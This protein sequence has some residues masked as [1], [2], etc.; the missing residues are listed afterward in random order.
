MLGKHRTGRAHSP[1]D[2]GDQPDT[3]RRQ[4]LRRAGL[5]GA[6]AAALAGTADLAGMSSALAAAGQQNHQHGTNRRN[7]CLSCVY[8]PGHCNGGRPCPSGQCC[9]RCTNNCGGTTTMCRQHSCN[10]WSNC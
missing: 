8:T 10:N 1:S 4:F 6:V 3:S 9:F 2:H 5:A 7:C